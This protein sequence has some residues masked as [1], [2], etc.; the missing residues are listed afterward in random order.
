MLSAL[1][2]RDNAP[3]NVKYG[4]DFDSE[5]YRL[6]EVDERLLEELLEDGLSIKGGADE[7]AVLCT[8]KATFAMKFVSTSNT[9]LLVPPAGPI[10]SASDGDYK[11]SPAAG[12][13]TDVETETNVVAT[14]A[15]HI[16]LVEIS[17]K[18]ENLKGLLSQRPYKEDVDGETEVEDGEGF[19]TWDDL[20]AR[21]QASEFQLRTALKA[22]HAVEIGGYWRIAAEEFMHEVLEMLLLTATQH[23]WPLGALPG[24]EV[25][26]AMGDDNYSPQIVIH[27]LQTYG[28]R[29]DLQPQDNVN[30]RSQEDTVTDLLGVE[31][32]WAL[33]EQKVCLEYA[34]RLLASFAK[35]KL[36]EFLESWRKALPA[37]MSPHLQMLRGEALVDVLGTDS[38]LQRFSISSLPRKP[39]ARFAALFKQRAKWEWDDLELYLRDLKE[40]NLSVE[41]MLLKYTRK[42]QPSANSPPVY[43]TR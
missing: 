6:L 32:T 28:V 34:K 12:L 24:L 10:N 30:L 43:T 2:L 31:T 7:E 3:V 38:W 25:V 39:E 20:L 36:Q 8:S 33:D 17:P 40:P 9:V 19:Y 42:T 14:A 11:D 35:W 15:G 4:Q 18:V 29:S 13:K 41:A 37:G 26:K 1:N 16:E 21:V 23:D 22:L 27:C 5:T